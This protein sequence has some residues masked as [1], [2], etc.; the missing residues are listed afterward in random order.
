MSTRD[1]FA[2]RTK[3]L[4]AERAAWRC[5]NPQCRASTLRP[6]MDDADRTVSTGCAAHIAAAAE[7][8]P[9]HDASQSSEE[10]RGSSNGIWLC[11]SCGDLV[12]KD[13][14]HY[15]SATLQSWRRA[16]DLFLLGGGILPS[17]PRLELE[18]ISGLALGM[19]AGAEITSEMVSALRQHKLK[20]AGTSR[21]ELRHI[22]LVVQFPERV[23]S[24]EFLE[25]PAGTRILWEP[26]RAGFVVDAGGGG[27]VT[28]VGAARP[29]HKFRL[30]VERLSE[31]RAVSV[32]ITT[33]IDEV[34]RRPSAFGSFGL[35]DGT[36]HAQHVRGSFEYADGVEI[37]E[38]SFVA[39]IAPVG[40]RQ[41]GVL[42]S[43]D[44]A[45][46]PRLIESHEM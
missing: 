8:G 7:R 24:C 11:R 38:R 44:A 29:V 41:Y 33:Y 1:N 21:H 13:R 2:E 19:Q 3:K 28:R 4:L 46:A 43:I 39:I 25:P 6:S 5:S 36:S 27:A 12:D 37:G 23:I 45:D 35:N 17:L 32:R 10:R 31:S 16:H 18:T 26:V 15:S 30:S 9:R 42:E 40:D 22:E 14:N 20:I 34:D